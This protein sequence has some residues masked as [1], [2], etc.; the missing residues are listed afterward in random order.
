MLLIAHR[1]GPDTYPEQTIQSCREALSLGADIVEID[2]RPT[3]DDQAAMCHDPNALRMF[4]VD[5]KI[6]DMTAAEFRLLRHVMDPA[7]CSHMIADVFATGLKP[8]LIHIK[9]K[10]VLPA[11][12]RVIDKYDYAE[13][14]TIGVSD[15]ESVHKIRSH[16]P[17]IKILCFSSAVEQIPGMVEAGADYVRL[18]ENW[19]TVEN[20][21]MVRD[22]GAQVW[23][24]SGVL[25]KNVGYPSEEDLK[26]ILSY[27]PDGLLINE[28]RFAKRVISEM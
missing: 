2:A 4:G 10:R 3:A 20:V 16:D 18:W 8:L 24:M 13:N 14:V 26:K 19:L 28:I 17:S 1:S 21:Q 25:H 5:K 12:L 7:F 6:T 23:V 27:K 15:V 9:D 22:L 11:L